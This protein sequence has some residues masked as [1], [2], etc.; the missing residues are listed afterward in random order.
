MALAAEIL[1]SRMLLCH[2]ARKHP[3]SRNSFTE[4]IWR[5]V[6]GTGLDGLWREKI[7]EI[8]HRLL[9]K[10]RRHWAFVETRVEKR[11]S[12]VVADKVPA[13]S[14]IIVVVVTCGVRGARI[15]GA[16]AGR[17]AVVISGGRWWPVL[18]VAG[19]VVR[20]KGCERREKRAETSRSASVVLESRRSRTGRCGACRGRVVGCAIGIVGVM[21]GMMLLLLEFPWRFAFSPF[22]PSILEPNLNARFAQLQTQGQFFASKHVRIRRSFKCS[23]QFF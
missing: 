7:P 18:T 13:V 21:V 5:F 15:T 12:A 4:I 2:P 1:N 14:W 22:G 3:C 11:I 23:F 19:R 8:R 6:S 10:T 17:I 16:T 9:V 20:R